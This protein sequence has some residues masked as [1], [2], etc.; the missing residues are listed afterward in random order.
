M[1]LYWEQNPYIT[2]SSINHE[3]EVRFGLLVDDD[4]AEEL[5]KKIYIY[6]I[7]LYQK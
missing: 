1:K 2:D 3:L 4:K 5:A 7:I 6:I